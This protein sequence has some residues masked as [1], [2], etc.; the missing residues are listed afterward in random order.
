[1]NAKTLFAGAALLGITAA[2]T[3]MVFDVDWAAFRGPAD[4]SRVEFFYAVP[5]FAGGT[6]QFDFRAED[7]LL[8]ARFALAFRL[9][10]DNGYE[11]SATL[12]KQVT[13]SS[14]VEAREA[15][16]QF[17][18]GFSLNVPP[19]RYRASFTLAQPGPGE[20]DTF[21]EKG[22]REDTLV[23]P[24]FGAG[25][26][27]SELQ[28]AAGVVLD[29]VSGGFSVVPHP[30]RGF[31]GDGLDR[32]YIYYEGYGLSPA[33]DSYEVETRMFS[34]AAETLVS[35]GPQVKPRA[36]TEVS[37]VLGVSVGKLKPGDYEVELV[38]RDRAGGSA[39]RRAAFHVSRPVQEP[40]D[41][42]PYQLALTP[43]EKKYYDR[44]EFIASGSEIAY[45]NSLSDSG[46]QA[47]LAWFWGRHNLSEFVRRMETANERYRT[48][49]TEGLKT[50]RGRMYVKYGEPEE[51]ERKVLEV[52]RRPRE[53]W[54]YYNQGYVF[55]FIDVTGTDNY[56][57]AWTNSPHEP[58]T[59]YERLLTPDEEEQ[60]K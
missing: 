44:L 37:S 26:H 12:Y 27:V 17:V 60:Y 45:F 19:G 5:I 55:I 57:L 29:T 10:G 54:Q 53:Y 36:G 38:L 3:G 59:G 28:L 40:G 7:T 4:S 23:V 31:G 51:V 20:G 33:A 58:A 34:T 47:Y 14:L 39:R 30:G 24:D 41:V 35:V 49:T 32:V 11:Q 2:A 48:S 18:D 9:A 25:M 21:V 16:R 50:D 43:L 15:R 22:R 46:K 1:M 52:D 13:L 6:P 42:T 8:V 56:K